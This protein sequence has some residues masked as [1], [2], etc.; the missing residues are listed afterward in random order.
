M[1]AAQAECYHLERFFLKKFQLSAGWRLNPLPC[2]SLLICFSPILKKVIHYPLNH[3]IPSRTGAIK[4][5]T[6]EIIDRLPIECQIKFWG[7]RWKISMKIEGSG[8]NPATNILSNVMNNSVFC[9]E[10]FLASRW[11]WDGYFVQKEIY[12][13]Y[14]NRRR[15]PYHHS[16]QN[17]STFTEEM[18][19][20]A[21]RPGSRAAA[22]RYF[23]G[24]RGQSHLGI[25]LTHLVSFSPIL[26]SRFD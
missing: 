19:V 3:S 6:F 5:V 9:K 10:N 22:P 21:G 14:L 23:R 4:G 15:V 1:I 17:Y 7:V 25:R 16:Y 11:F 18:E 13:K 24:L 8:A 2:R 20:P 12:E 26:T